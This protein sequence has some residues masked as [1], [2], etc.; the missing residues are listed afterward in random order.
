MNTTDYSK[1]ASI[2]KRQVNNLPLAGFQSQ[3]EERQTIIVSRDKGE[4]REHRAINA[5][6]NRVNRYRIDGIVITSGSACD[7]LLIN[8]DVLSAYFIELKGSDLSQAARQLESSEAALKDEL[9]AYKLNFRIV[10]SK[11]RTH[12]I[13]GVTFRRFKESKKTSLKYS[14]NRIEEDI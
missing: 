1:Y 10:A 8:E 4:R 14:T 11:A 6:R 12:A 9:S 13:E 2:A 3:C 7:F 5:N